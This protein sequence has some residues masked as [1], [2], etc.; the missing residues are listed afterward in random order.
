M[1]SGDQNVENSNSGLSPP[2][3]L[4]HQKKVVVASKPGGLLT[5]GPPGVDSFELRVKR[6]IV[7][8]RTTDRPAYLGVPHRLDRPASG[9]MVFALDRTTARE[10]ARQFEHRRIK[11][12]YWCIV[13]GLIDQSD[14]EW[15][16]FMRKIPSEAKSEIVDQQHPGAQ[17]AV[18]KY[19]VMSRANGRSLLTIQLETGRTHQ[20]RLQAASRGF[21][22]LGDAMYG[23]SIAFGPQ[24]DDLRL[25]HIALHARQIQFEHPVKNETVAITAALPKTWN[26]FSDQLNETTQNG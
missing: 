21:P 23:S 9:A 2:E 8:A 11:K 3:V 15:V 16:D 20:I 24:T 10:L 22:I 13:G 12:T 5:Q 14:G 19:R 7:S 1:F 26:E 25:R 18:L 6:W 17:L 4:Y